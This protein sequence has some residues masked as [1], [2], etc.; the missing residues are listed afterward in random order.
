MHS[1][2]GDRL[3]WNYGAAAGASAERFL[4][5]REALVP[6]TYTLAQQTNATGVPIIRLLYLN[7]PDNSEACT[8]TPG[9]TST[10]TTCSWRRSP[11]RMTPVATAR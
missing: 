6:Y 1:D 2:H 4:R 7:Y 9:N 8:L 10:A 11:R 5:L 3:P